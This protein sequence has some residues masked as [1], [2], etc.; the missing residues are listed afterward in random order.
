[1]PKPRRGD[2]EAWATGAG[3]PPGSPRAAARPFVNAGLRCARPWGRHGR[4]QAR[5]EPPAAPDLKRPRGIRRSH[6][7]ALCHGMRLETAQAG[8]E[9]GA[10]RPLKAG[11][12]GCGRRSADRLSV[13]PAGGDPWGGP[14]VS[15]CVS[16]L[17]HPDSARP[18]EGAQLRARDTFVDRVD[19]DDFAHSILLFLV[20][21]VLKI[22]TDIC[23]WLTVVVSGKLDCMLVFVSV[24]P[25]VSY[26]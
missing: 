23:R 10:M 16:C 12:P 19:V 1:M 6:C 7:D 14:R 4:C 21:R 26:K 5:G 13:G 17:L 18:V 11:G 24:F 3:P 25:H 2:E 8:T 9:R 15:M 22:Y 20:A